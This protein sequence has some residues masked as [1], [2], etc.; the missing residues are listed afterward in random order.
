M[1]DIN[2]EGI[3][4]QTF[5]MLEAN[6]TKE[7]QFV[8]GTGKLGAI[9]FTCKF[10]ERMGETPESIDEYI[11]KLNKVLPDGEYIFKNISVICPN[12]KSYFTVF[13]YIKEL[14]DNNNI[15]Y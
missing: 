13:D 4:E 5:A 10:L 12:G 15:K 2:L 7:R 8:I 6:I 3:V 14:Q 1:E 11:V 9:Q